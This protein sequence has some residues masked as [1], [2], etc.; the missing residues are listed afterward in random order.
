MCDVA[1]IAGV[2]RQCRRA[3]SE[4]DFESPCRRFLASHCKSNLAKT[5]SSSAE[6]DYKEFLK[7]FLRGNKR[8]H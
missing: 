4:E 1:H 8:V 6:Q 5:P 3:E 7:K 2:K